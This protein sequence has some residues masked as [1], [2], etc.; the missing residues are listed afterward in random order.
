M[1]TIPFDTLKFANR[2]KAAGFSD[3]QAEAMAEAQAEVFDKNLDE[4]A[5]KRDL[6]ELKL[7]MSADMAKIHGELATLRWG[8]AVT[9]GGVVALI[10]KSFFPH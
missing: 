5:N 1:T 10:L 4:L 7:E 2:M 3:R 8:M 9:V 6:R